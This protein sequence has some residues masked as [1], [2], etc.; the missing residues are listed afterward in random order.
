MKIWVWK[1]KYSNYVIAMD[2]G[3]NYPCRCQV[4]INAMNDIPDTLDISLKCI[5]I[6]KTPIWCKASLWL[7]ILACNSLYGVI[8]KLFIITWF[9]KS[10]AEFCVWKNYI[11]AK[12]FKLAN[13]PSKKVVL[14]EW[15]ICLSK[16]VKKAED[17]D[18]LPYFYHCNKFSSIFCF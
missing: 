10:V 11:F 16:R 3:F 1:C 12:S 5:N 2:K 14:C 6:I 13:I 15:K 17:F 8:L 7:L 4:I 9:L 18:F